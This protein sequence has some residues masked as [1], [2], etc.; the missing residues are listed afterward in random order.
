[1]AAILAGFECGRL[2]WN[3][4]DLLVTTMHL[5]E[6]RMAEHYRIVR[7]HGLTK[8][9]DGL[10]WRHDPVARM[11]TARRQ[12]LDVIWD[13]N[14]FDP[15]DD[16]VAH[17]RRVAKA[18]DPGKPLWLCPVNEPSVYP[19]LCG[20]AVEDAVALAITM[21]TVARDHH[22]DVRFLATDPLT[23]IGE[24]QF[25]ALD[26]LVTAGV[27]DIVGVNYYP[28]NARTSLSKV[29]T[30]VARRY[31]K[32]IMVAETSW[33]DGHPAHHRGRPGWRK[34]DWLRYVW[35]E[36]MIAEARGADVSGV[37]WYPIIDS[38]PWHRPGSRTRWSHGLI[39]QDLSVDPHLAEAL[40]ERCAEPRQLTFDDALSR[41]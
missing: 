30:K 6:R 17:A 31:R 4:H 2:G 40:A 37:C 21:A 11:R 23:G 1:M 12:K 16:P 19:M 5:P 10:P 7:A 22:P 9:R 34:G 36:V 28:H 8:A 39:R 14:H 27:V 15:P 29:L 33:H 26:R 38:P 41:L 25:H 18:A 32:P 13:L 35:D 3:G 24:R 20:I